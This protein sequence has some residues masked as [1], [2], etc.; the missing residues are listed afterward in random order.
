MSQGTGQEVLGLSA[1]WVQAKQLNLKWVQARVSQGTLHSG[2]SGRTVEAEM[3]ASQGL[4]GT[5]CRGYPGEAAGA[6]AVGR[7]GGPWTFCTEGAL[8]G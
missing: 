7:L 6:E 5:L 1:Q 8:A 4:W 3:G 2:H